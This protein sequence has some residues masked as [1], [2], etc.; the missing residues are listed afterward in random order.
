[1][2]QPRTKLKVKYIFRLR[3]ANSSGNLVALAMEIYSICRPS[4]GTAS[5]WPWG[6]LALAPHSANSQSPILTRDAK[7]LSDGCTITCCKEKK[8]CMKRG[9]WL[10]V[11]KRDCKHIVP[12]DDDPGHPRSPHITLII[13]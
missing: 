6:V 9:L 1:M 13:K 11:W 12:R 2:G 8:E 5:A 7:V 3:T 10:P 4:L